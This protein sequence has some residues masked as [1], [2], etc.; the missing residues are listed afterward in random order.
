METIDV[1]AEAFDQLDADALADFARA[2]P[3]F[4]ATTRRRAT[5]YWNEHHRHRFPDKRAYPGLT[6]LDRIERR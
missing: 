5:S 4:M 3:A 1:I 2:N 6:L